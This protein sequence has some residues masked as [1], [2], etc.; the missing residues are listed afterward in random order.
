MNLQVNWMIY[1]KYRKIGTRRVHVSE[2]KN[3]RPLSSFWWNSA[4]MKLIH[5]D[6]D[7]RILVGFRTN[8]NVDCA[9][10]TALHEQ[11]VSWRRTDLDSLKRW[12]VY[13]FFHL[14]LKTLS[15]YTDWTSFT[16]KYFYDMFAMVERWFSPSWFVFLAIVSFS[17]FR[18]RSFFS[19]YN[20]KD[21]ISSYFCRQ[22]SERSP[23]NPS[24]FTDF[25]LM[26]A[27]RTCRQH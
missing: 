10:L 18:N 20:S 26:S 1:H 2:R 19:S 27:W 4:Q 14:N 12:S 9:I 13:K 8:T 22:H 6:K 25:K 23:Q 16:C 24:I 11:F 17:F 15:L 21:K 7:K 3:G 5:L